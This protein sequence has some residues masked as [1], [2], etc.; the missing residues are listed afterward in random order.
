[1]K[2]TRAQLMSLYQTKGQQAFSDAS[3]FK[4][5]GFDKPTKAEVIE[6]IEQGKRDKASKLTNSNIELKEDCQTAYR[7]RLNEAKTFLHKKEIGRLIKGFDQKELMT[8]SF[9][10]P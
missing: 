2:P 3:V 5:F 1:M 4:L 9:L 10:K 7:R 8:N 6:H